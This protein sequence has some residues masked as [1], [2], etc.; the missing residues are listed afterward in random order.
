MKISVIAKPFS[1]I[2]GITKIDETN[3]I[4]RVKEKPEDGKANKAI[5]KALSKYFKIPASEIKIISGHFS[6]IK[7]I[8]IN[9]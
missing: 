3:F 4:V 5:V 7:I 8:S 1:K 2:E 9:L 6:K